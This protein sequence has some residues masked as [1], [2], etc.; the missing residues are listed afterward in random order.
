MIRLCCIL[1]PILFLSAT[2]SSPEEGCV[3]SLDVIFVVDASGSIQDQPDGT[4]NAAN[5]IKLLS[6]VKGLS[7]EFA[8][9]LGD[10]RFAQV[11]FSDRVSLQFSFTSDFTFI[12]TAIDSTPYYGSTTNIAGG[13]EEATKAIGNRIITGR[14]VAV[15]LITDGYANVNE[16]RTQ[17]AAAEVRNVAEAIHAVGITD[18]VNRNELLGIV[19]GKADNIVLVTN[20]DGLGNVI[21]PLVDSLCP[22]RGKSFEYISFLFHFMVSS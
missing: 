5:W 18:A 14:K 7:L 3:S 16:G 12:N 8:Q 22:G 10:V 6:F 13:L 2:T 20:F 21:A 15:I 11:V 1:N 4:R 19:G 9:K 17:T